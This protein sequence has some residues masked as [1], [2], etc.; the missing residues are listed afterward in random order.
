MLYS[1]P[2]HLVHFWPQRRHPLG[3]VG[4]TDFWP[5]LATV[6]PIVRVPL[7]MWVPVIPVISVL[8]VRWVA[9]EMFPILLLSFVGAALACVQ[10]RHLPRRWFLLAAAGRISD[11]ISLVC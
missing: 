8:I 2:K 9:L 10:L 11:R 3:T 5:I 1:K 4:R 7:L 6:I